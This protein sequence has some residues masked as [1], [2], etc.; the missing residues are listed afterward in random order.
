LYKAVL[1]A[2]KISFEPEQIV[3]FESQGKLLVIGEAEQ[4]AA[5]MPYLASLELFCVVLDDGTLSDA[6]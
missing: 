5:V 1:D 3:E 4:L 2:G 6:E